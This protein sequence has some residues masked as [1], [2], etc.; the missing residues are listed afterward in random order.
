M[1]NQSRQTRFP[2]PG[3]RNQGFPGNRRRLAIARQPS[4][5]RQPRPGPPSNR[6][7]PQPGRLSGPGPAGLFR[8]GREV[9][10]QLQWRA[11][12]GRCG[13]RCAAN[14]RWLST[15]GLLDWGRSGAQ[16]DQLSPSPLFRRIQASMRSRGAGDVV[17]LRAQATRAGRQNSVADRYPRRKRTPA[18]R[19]GNRF[20]LC[21]LHAFL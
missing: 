3:K 13:S 20:Q 8:P 10:C 6:G 16:A 18:W 1:V 9:L 15:C 19:I 5:F 11:G 12:P 14:R 7:W 17:L 21:P 4:Q 2:L